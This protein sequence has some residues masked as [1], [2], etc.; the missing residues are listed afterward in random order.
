[1]AVAWGLVHRSLD[2]VTANR[3]R[4]NLLEEERLQVLDTDLPDRRPMQ[5]AAVDR[6]RPHP[7]DPTEL[8][9]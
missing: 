4:R 3:H 2:N 1:M 5:E 9:H 7:E 6:Q 8:L